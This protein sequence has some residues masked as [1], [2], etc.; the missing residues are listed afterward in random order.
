MSVP[1]AIWGAGA[2]GGTL[3]AAFI[4]SGHDVVFIDQAADHVAAINAQG[5]RIDGPI[6]Q[7]TVKARAFLPGEVACQFERIFLSVKA[8]HTEAATEALKPHLA[9]D[10]FVVSAQN[11]L[12]EL[13]ISRIVGLPRVVGAFV[14][15]GAD[16]LEPGVIH[17]SGRGTMVVG[18]LDGRRTPRIEAIHGLMSTLDPR[19]VLSNNVWGFLW[20]KM[21]YG[22]QLFATALTND[23]I[24]DVFAMERYRPLLTDLAIEIAAVAEAQGIR[25]EPFDGFDPTAFRPGATRADTWRSFDE[26][27]AHNR[28]STKSHS[29]IWR[30]IAIRKRKTEVD[31][32]IA[33][34]VELGRAAGVPTPLTARLVRM[35]HEVEELRRPLALQNLDELA[36]TKAAG[37][38]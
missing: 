16:Y 1:I 30:D 18:E 17:Y 23:S 27:V 37:K 5:L 2:I 14:N 13:V 6:F 31:G 29:G 21:I 32:Q 4:R 25:L 9:D 19:A 35:I 33:P 7:D 22:A 28:R 26:M 11:G 36:E 38:V 3:G 8:H 12:N 24:A 20:G 10:G 34:I 15:F